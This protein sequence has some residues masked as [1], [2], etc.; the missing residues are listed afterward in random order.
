MFRYINKNGWMTG[1]TG[2]CE[3]KCNNLKI[4]FEGEDDPNFDPNTPVINIPL[5]SLGDILNRGYRKA[6]IGDYWTTTESYTDENGAYN[7]VITIV[8]PDESQPCIAAE[9][10]DYIRTFLDRPGVLDNSTSTCE[11]VD[12]CV[13][14]V[15]LHF[16]GDY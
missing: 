10:C 13:D 11:F 16:T 1:V 4:I 14:K 12:G 9:V 15:L 6:E 2:R 5:K 7:I 3:T 8:V